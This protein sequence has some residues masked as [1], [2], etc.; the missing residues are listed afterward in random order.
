MLKNALSDKANARFLLVN[1]KMHNPN[2]TSDAV[3]YLNTYSMKLKE[4]AKK[5]E[6]ST[7]EAKKGFVNSF[8]W[9]KMTEQ[10]K[11]VWEE[12]FKTLEK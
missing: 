5:G 2:Y 12:I 4:K 8:D 6:L 3:K 7:S 10:D 9:Y 11:S 1:G